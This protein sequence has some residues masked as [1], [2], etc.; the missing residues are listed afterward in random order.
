[1]HLWLCR[2]YRDQRSVMDLSANY[3]AT[4]NTPRKTAVTRLHVFTWFLCFCRQMGMF[5]VL[6]FILEYICMYTYAYP[7]T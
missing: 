4:L 6:L 3:L 1:M 2:G 7:N 5:L